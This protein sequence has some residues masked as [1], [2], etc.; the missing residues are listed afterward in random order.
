MDSGLCS[1][2]FSTTVHPAARAGPIFH[3]ARVSGKFH[4]TTAATTPAGSRVT[5]ASSPG[6]VGGISP[7]CLSA[8]SP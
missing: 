4:G 3:P 8:S 6:T 7:A 5:S 2:V 1:A